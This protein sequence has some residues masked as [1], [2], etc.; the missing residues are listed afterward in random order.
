VTN[1]L[2]N[3]NYAGGTPTTASAAKGGALD[4]SIISSNNSNFGGYLFYNSNTIKGKNT[5]SQTTLDE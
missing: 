4:T 3:H 2:L 5:S 1:L